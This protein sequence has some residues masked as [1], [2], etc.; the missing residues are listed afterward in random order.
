MYVRNIICHALVVPSLSTFLQSCIYG[1][2]RYL[3]KSS[4]CLR[5]VKKI[6]NAFFRV[7]TAIETDDAVQI[8]EESFD[9]HAFYGDTFNTDLTS[10]HMCGPMQMQDL[11]L[12]MHALCTVV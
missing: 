8:S 11:Y 4:R 12:W 1:P 10:W 6:D 3:Y 5:F 2:T 9:M 7:L